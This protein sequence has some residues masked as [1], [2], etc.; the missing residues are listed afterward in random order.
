MPRSFKVVRGLWRTRELYKFAKIDKEVETEKYIETIKNSL[1]KKVLSI[2]TKNSS[3]NL[4]MIE[5]L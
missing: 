5:L 4:I 1:N 2:F 3:L